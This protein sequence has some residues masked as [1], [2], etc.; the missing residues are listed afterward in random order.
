MVQAVSDYSTL[1]G[2]YIKTMDTQFIMGQLDI[3]NDDEWQA[4]LDTLDSM[5]LQ[6]YIA[7][8]EIYYGLK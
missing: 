8:L 6:D 5:G 7:N 4:Y 2:D 1:I 3:H